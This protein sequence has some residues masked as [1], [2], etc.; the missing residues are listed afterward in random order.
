[1]TTESGM[2]SARATFSRPNLDAA[3]LIV[4]APRFLNSSLTV[5]FAMK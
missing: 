3:H 2:D 4:L 5:K 1:M